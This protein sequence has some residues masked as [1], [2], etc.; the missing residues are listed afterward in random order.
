MEGQLHHLANPHLGRP[1]FMW[2]YGHWGPPVLVFPSAAGMAHEWQ[3]HS[4]IDTHADLLS[5]G[6]LKLYCVESNVADSWT[7]KE[8]SLEGKMERHRAYERFILENVVPFI[9]EDCRTEGIPITAVGISVGALLAV[10]F[11]LKYPQVF[12]HAIGFSGRYNA[13]HFTHG[14]SNDDVYF[15]NPLAYVPGLSGEV[16]EH[17]RQNA[18]FTLV[19]GQG[20][21]EDGNIEETV[22]MGRLLR[23]KDIACETDIWGRDSHHQW[24]YWKLQSRKYFQQLFGA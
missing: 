22:M 21:W 4:M 13:M 1:G 19:C 5:A 17:V 7:N 20:K 6:R 12:H 9:Y 15:N 10:N 24:P 18:R 2:C 8:R 14:Q 3:A 16:L 23:S 11:A